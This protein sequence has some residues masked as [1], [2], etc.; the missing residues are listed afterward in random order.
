MP[1]CRRTGALLVVLLVA[2]LALSGCASK[3]GKGGDGAGPSSGT[4]SGSAST[5]G[6]G[7]KG[8][9]ASGSASGAPGANLPPTATIKAST[10]NGTAPLNVSLTLGGADPEG[11]P[12]AWNL[13]FDGNGTADG[14]ALPDTVNRTLQAGNHTF[15][16]TVSD[17]KASTRANVTIVVA[18]GAGAAVGPQHWYITDNPD[19]T[20]CTAGFLVHKLE[21]AANGFSCTFMGQNPV[22]GTGVGKNIHT[23]VAQEGSA[24]QPAGTQVN[25]QVWFSWTGAATGDVTF[26]L[27]ADGTVLG[28]ASVDFT[29]A[30]TDGMK[31]V[32][33]AF[34]TTGPIAANAILTLK[35]DIEAPNPPGTFTHGVGKDA[36]SGFAVGTAYAP[37]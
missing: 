5:S 3:G 10:L 2:A 30:P 28:T 26:T 20:S 15:V 22:F 7:T 21:G 31:P 24:A 16:L 1:A 35:Y 37:A 8:S 6:S 18:P 25:G 11:Q 19:S 33:F 17:G 13:T 36:P 34:T 29:R 27:D 4:G 23:M 32:D 12:L 9:A 14:T